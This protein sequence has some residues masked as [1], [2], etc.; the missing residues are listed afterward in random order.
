M[1]KILLGTLMLLGIRTFLPAQQVAALPEL[2]LEGE[3]IDE[4]RT[5]D[6]ASDI[7]LGKGTRIVSP[8][9]VTVHGCHSIRFEEGFQTVPGTELVA[10]VD[11]NCKQAG[12]TAISMSK[13]KVDLGPNPFQDVLYLSVESPGAIAIEASLFDLQGRLAATLIS[14]H[15]L[16]EG[17]HQIK[18]DL[19][20]LPTGTYFYRVQAGQEHFSG[21]LVHLN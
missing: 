7:V 4:A 6:G 1:K 11:E 20:H 18:L 5:I 21:K 14:E 3:L 19:G 15:M 10:S 8:V 17:H 2:Q 13:S 16:A 9:K 12:A